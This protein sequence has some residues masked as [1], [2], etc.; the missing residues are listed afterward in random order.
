M[1]FCSLAYDQT[2]PENVTKI[3]SE[4]LQFFSQTYNCRLLCH[5]LGGSNKDEINWINTERCTCDVWS[6]YAF[7]MKRHTVKKQTALSL[8]AKAEVSR[9]EYSLAL[10]GALCL[11]HCVRLF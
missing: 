8:E 9:T 11:S 4:L 5:L 6:Q 1:I 3:S 7:V 2:F 10:C